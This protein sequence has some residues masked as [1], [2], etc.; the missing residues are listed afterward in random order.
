[1]KAIKGPSGFN[2]ICSY[3]ILHHNVGKWGSILLILALIIVFFNTAFAVSSS[4]ISDDCGEDDCICFIQLG[5]SGGFVKGIINLLKEQDYLTSVTKGNRFTTDV[6]DAVMRFQSNHGLPQ[7]G[8]M[9]DDTLTLLIWGLAAE[10]LDI[11]MPVVPGSCT[12]YPDLVYVPTDGGKKRHSI[13]TC[14]E[15][16]NPRKVSIR[17]AEAIGYTPCKKCEVEREQTLH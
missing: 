2:S 16:Y 8:M 12:T 4:F 9:D 10:E 13:P 5:D 17:N 11:Q 14:S 3:H 6:R 7:T 15:M 1:M